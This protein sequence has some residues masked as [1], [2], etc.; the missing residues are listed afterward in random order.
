MSNYLTTLLEGFASLVTLMGLTLVLVLVLRHLRALSVLRQR[1]A[2]GC[3]F[4]T[5][6][7][8]AMLVPF[9]IS[10]GVYGDMRNV[11]VATAVFT[12]GPWASF[13]AAAMA[14]T[15]RLTEGGEALGGVIG[16]FGSAAAASVLYQTWFARHRRPGVLHFALLGAAL[17]LV[18][19]LAPLAVSLPAGMPLEKNLFITLFIAGA[20]LLVYPP[21]V[22]MV[23]KFID[24]EAR[25]I[26]DEN[27]LKHLNARLASRSEELKKLNESL[28]HEIAERRQ[29]EARLH[30]LSQAIEQSPSSVLI[31]NAEGTIEYVNAAFQ[32]Q[33]GYTAD[34]VIGGDPRALGLMDTSQSRFSPLWQTVRSGR[35]WRGEMFNRKKNGDPLWE[36]TT[37][38]PVKSQSGTITHFVAMKEDIT[39][40][41][42]YEDQLRRQLNF[43]TVTGLPN[44]VLAMDRLNQALLRA[45][46]QHRC[47]LLLSIDL[48]QFKKINDVLGH[49]QGDQFLKEAGQRLA[50]CFREGDTVARL[51][52]NKYA[53][54]I[55]D[56]ADTLEAG[57]FA[58][59]AFAAFDQ[60]FTYDNH[61]FFITASIGISMSPDDGETSDTLLRNADAA[62]YDAKRQGQN[63]VRFFKPEMNERAVTRV[64]IEAALRR[65]L[66]NGELYLRYQPL[67]CLRDEK[68]IGVEALVRWHSAELGEVP[69]DDFIRVAEEIG[70]IVR[71]GDWVLET[72]VRQFVQWRHRGLDLAKICVN[73]SSRQFRDPTLLATL[74]RLIDHHDL[75]PGSIE[76]E[77]TESLLMQD[78]PEAK[79]AM[80]AI[81]EMGVD[82]AVDDFG[83]GFSSLAY[84][85]RFPVDTLKI[86][87][88]FVGDLVT[89]QGDAELV[90]TII[91]LGQTLGMQVIAEG[92]ETREQM[93]FLKRLDCDIGQGYYLSKPLMADEIEDFVHRWNGRRRLVA[94]G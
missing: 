91:R 6:A 57:K 94:D 39:L 42:Q 1:V 64:R 23:G 45:N 51:D 78:N 48:D 11:A 7:I 3:A 79:H 14:A 86:D 54:I 38:A 25:R 47:V 76:L 5:I 93:E 49:E 92:V 46:R 81:G 13:I 43:D 44:R 77:I 84:L 9:E 66:A 35:V 37:I 30:R 12:G 85:R 33:T 32:R 72:A 83:T 89:N 20:G 18:N 58:N 53:V 31:T 40:R 52:G 61:E 56:L 69:P 60:P 8:G 34:E 80:D 4:G 71:I 62:M 26:D 16:I 67:V 73:T 21:T 70:E 29:A 28:N 22:L 90:T 41:K 17:A 10:P 24:L 74:R 82:L 19:A 75:S 55:P 15:F 2:F 50:T 88:S 68:V 87:R 63:S 59:K 65:A 27:D 36:Y